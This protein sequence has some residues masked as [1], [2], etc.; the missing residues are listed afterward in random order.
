[1][2]QWKYLLINSYNESN[3]NISLDGAIQ[4]K[5]KQIVAFDGRKS[6]KVSG[7]AWIVA[8]I[9]GNEL[10]FGTNPDFGN[11]DQI[12]SHRAEIYRVLSV[13]LIIQEYCNFYMLKLTKNRILLRQPQSRSQIKTLATNSNHFNEQYKTK[14]HD[15]VLKLREYLPPNITVFHVKGHQDQRKINATLNHS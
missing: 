14:D 15:T 2:F 6:K 8:D 9:S 3:L 7:G 10:I 11:I 12:H 4:M 5:H 1:M 13:F